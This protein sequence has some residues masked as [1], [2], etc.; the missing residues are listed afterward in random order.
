MCVLEACSRFRGHSLVSCVSRLQA[1]QWFAR[2]SYSSVK[3]VSSPV[4][5]SKIVSLISGLSPS[6]V[7][8]IDVVSLG[9]EDDVGSEITGASR[10]RGVAVCR[11]EEY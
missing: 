3:M 9:A 6:I 4:E 1:L 8:L 11:V 5:N 2:L 7:A 10:S